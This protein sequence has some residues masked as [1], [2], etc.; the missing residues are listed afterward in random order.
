MG[1]RGAHERDCTPPRVLLSTDSRRDAGSL[2]TIAT[3]VSTERGPSAY[4]GSI[5]NS[6]VRFFCLDRRYSRFFRLPE[7]IGIAACYIFSG[8]PKGTERREVVCN[9]RRR[10]F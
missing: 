9:G 1:G 6:S 10:M 5:L 3:I 4:N 7:R 8:G 2:G